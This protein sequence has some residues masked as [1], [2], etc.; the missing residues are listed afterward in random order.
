MTKQSA[1]HAYDVLVDAQEK[2][3][4]FLVGGPE[5]ITE[6]SLKPTLVTNISRD[7]QIF[8]DET[9]G[10]SASVYMAEDDDDAI[11]IANDSSYGLNAAV[12]SSSWEHAYDVGKQLEYGQ[13]QI[14][15]LTTMDSR[16]SARC[17][18]VSC[19][20]FNSKPTDT[21]CQRVR[22]GPVEFHMGYP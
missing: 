7:A 17:S 16:K 10:P 15:S 11:A 22:L 19:L 18:Q 13:V 5:Y 8:D 2:G 6:T 1:T 3:G 4:K 21:W 14:N 20:M 9:F 12:H